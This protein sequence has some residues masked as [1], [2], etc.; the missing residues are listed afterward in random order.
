MAACLSADRQALKSRVVYCVWLPLWRS[1]VRLA[2]G[3]ANRYAPPPDKKADTMASADSRSL[4][5]ILENRRSCRAFLPDS[6][7]DEALRNLLAPSL[8]AP[9]NCNTQPWYFHVASGPVLEKLR[10]RLPEDFLAGRIK[11]DFPFDGKYEGVFKERQHA[12]AQALYGAMGIARE[13]RDGR[14]EAFMRNF[15]FFDAPHAGF[16]FLP[17]GFSEREA[18][19]LG[20]FAQSVMLL[21]EDAGLASCPQTALSFLSDSVREELSVPQHQRLMFG[22][23]FGY[24]DTD[25]PA[26]RCVTDRADVNELISLHR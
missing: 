14:Q 9:S 1:P 23:S 12:S 5:G 13:D 15:R 4:R 3:D 22:L 18:C 25:A 10:K 17:E 11:L 24:P 19:D 20:M 6:L 2:M 21:L 26:N 7:S 16:F 8:R